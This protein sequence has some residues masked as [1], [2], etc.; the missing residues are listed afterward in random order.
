ME[1]YPLITLL[2]VG[3]ILLEWKSIEQYVRLQS[4]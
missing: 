1:I 2:A 3:D 4:R